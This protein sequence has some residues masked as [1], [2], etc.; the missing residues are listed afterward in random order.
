MS[1]REAA[2]AASGASYGLGSGGMASRVGFEPFEI[3][4]QRRAR[5]AGAG[6][7][8]DDP[9]A[10]LQ[11]DADPL[12]LRHRE[13]DRVGI[14]ELVGGRDRELRGA[15]SGQVGKTSAQPVDHLAGGIRRQ[16]FVIVA[17]VEISAVAPPVVG[18]DR[19]GR[20]APHGEHAEPEQD[21][22]HAVLLADVVGPGAGALLAA[23][24]D[25]AGIE[26]RAEIFPPRRRLV[27]VDAERGGD[28]IHGAAGRHRARD[29]GQ[30]VLEPGDEPR[31][32]G[33]H[34]QAV[35]RRDHRCS[36]P[37]TILRSPSPSEAAPKSGP[38]GSDSAAMRS[39][40]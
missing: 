5:G 30:S 17:G 10:A 22:P 3:N 39:A 31:V 32:G 35:A 11:L 27:A 38:A 6:Q 18:E 40:A 9:G 1:A 15:A 4:A 13:V 7:P 29:A 36:R 25:A 23:Q 16:A 14:G 8:V 21:G 24:R 33:Q 20:L 19:G 12:P 34:R 28:A 26:Q 2:T 37:T